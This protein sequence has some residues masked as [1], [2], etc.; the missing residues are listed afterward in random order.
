MANRGERGLVLNVFIADATTMGCEL[1][2]AALRRS[3]YHLAVAG[4]STDSNGFR[5][6]IGNSSA[7][8]DVALI[9]AHLRDG[10]FAGFN[11]ARDVRRSYPS[12]SIITLLDSIERSAVVGAFR[13]GATGILTR[14]EPFEIVCKC[15]HKVYQG[16][17][18]AS[19]KAM[20]FALGALAQMGT[21]YDSPVA[22]KN[23][24][25]RAVLTKREEGVVQ[26]VSE[27]CTNRDISRQLRLSENTVRNYLFRIFNKVGTSNRLELALYV[28]NRKTKENLEAQEVNDLRG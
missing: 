15:I 1:M 7:G 19:S 11:L 3:R 4:S 17:V 27:G 28:L 21:D 23:S 12:T 24:K 9:S 22:P 25:G 8:V 14:E 5:S 16:E 13:S 10:P 20:Q 2:A 26:L 18:W 6:G